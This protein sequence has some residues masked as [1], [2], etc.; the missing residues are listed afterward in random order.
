MKIFKVIF[1]LM[2]AIQLLSSCAPEELNEPANT[3]SRASIRFSLSGSAKPKTA[4]RADAIPAEENEKTVNSLLAVLFDTH[5][6]FY[7]T[8]EAVNTADNEY[9]VLVEDDA[10]YDIWFVANANDD[11]R[12]KLESI[13]HDTQAQDAVSCF[14]KI[15]ATQ[16]PDSNEF[17]MISSSLK[18][19]T[20]TL[21]TTEDLGNIY[22]T[23]QAARF[24]IV[25]KAEGITVDKITF[26]N[27]AVKTALKK[28]NY[29][30]QEAGW[31]DTKEY[32]PENLVGNKENP[33]T[34]RHAIYSYRNTSL[35]PD[36]VPV[37]TLEYTEKTDDGKSVK[38]SHEVKL[39]DPKSPN[40][41]PLA[42]T[43][44]YLYTITLTKAYKL[45]VNLSVEDWNEAEVIS[46]PNLPIQ[47]DPEVQDELNKQL[48]VYDLFAEQNVKS[49]NGSNVEFFDS[50]LPANQYPFD[51]FFSY[52]DLSKQ[53]ITSA[54]VFSSTAS[55]GT[56][57]RLPT[58]GE[59]LLLAPFDV[60]EDAPDYN[61]EDKLPRPVPIFRKTGT[62]YVMTDKVFEEIV[63]LKNNAD[64]TPLVTEDMN[65]SSVAF[66]GSSQLMYGNN[67]F[68]FFYNNLGYVDETQN[69]T[70]GGAYIYPCYG[71]RFKDTDQYSAYMWTPVVRDEHNP[72]IYY[73]SI[74]IKALPQGCEFT[75]YDIADN[76][77][78]WKDGFIEIR[79][80]YTGFV[81]N[82]A[83]A[84]NTR[85]T[86]YLMPLTK[87]KSGN[88]QSYYFN[89]SYTT[90]RIFKG[91]MNLKF[92]IRLVKIKE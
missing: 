36:S 62:S 92:P 77:S 83:S 40:N 38:R 16:K 57:Y 8:V 14:E 44:N 76:V 53:G 15:F 22:M 10:T 33:S 50:F 35:N 47:L 80:P 75:V 6:G 54:S 7:Q 78:F 13:P 24:D 72:D 60:V 26:A 59:M 46:V 67:G 3:L 64:G 23:R 52:N 42:V 25:N 85:T 71:I 31:F 9:E 21:T 63:Y 30:P 70:G 49:F 45:E 88:N 11:L 65:D 20:T 27:R 55:D 82:G 2:I 69:P 81:S 17:V 32:T 5:K 12:T 91:N 66:R 68:K 89:S 1:S 28:P 61:I 73:S 39:I 79:I 58:Y 86:A 90:C 4:T 87:Y 56:K 19:V 29:M 41:T 34:Y 18:R 37:I 51:A 48:L 74:K 43:A 84:A